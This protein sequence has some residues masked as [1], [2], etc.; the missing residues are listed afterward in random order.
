MSRLIHRSIVAIALGA[1]ASVAYIHDAPAESAA[2]ATLEAGELRSGVLEEIV[3][4]ARKR[5][6]TLQVAP[7]SVTAISGANLEKAQIT[8]IDDLAQ[9]APSLNISRQAGF[10]NSVTVIM[11]GIGDTDP[12]L[13]N[14]SPVAIY[15]DGVYLGRTI[16]S[17]IDLSDLDR[18]E[19]LRGPQGT[20]FGRNTTGGA[21]DIYTK[22]PA[23]VFGLK[24]TLGYASNNEFTSQTFINTG[25][26]G[27][28]GFA[29]K[30]GYRHHQMDGFVNNT[31]AARDA[32]PGADKKDAVY[33]ALRGDLTKD[34]RLDY[35]FD[36]DDESDYSPNYQIVGATPKVVSYFSKS[37]LYGGAPFTPVTPDRLGTVQNEVLPPERLRTL[38]HNVT[39][40]DYVSDAFRIKSITA[41][42]SL[43]ERGS[44]TLGDSGQLKG[45]VFFSATPQNVYLYDT[46]LSNS[47]QH[48]LSEELQF[49][50][51]VDRFN[52]V[53]GLY[54]FDEHVGEQSTTLLTIPVQLGPTFI[55]GFPTTLKLNYTGES[56]SY[57]GYG[58]ASYT[59]PI[60]D[61]KLELTV[62]IRYTKDRKSIEQNDST[63]VRYLRRSFSNTSP[64]FTAK[65]EW[66]RDL[67]TYFRFAQGYKAGGYSARSQGTGYDPEKATSY[68]VGV[69]SEWLDQHLRIN[70]DVYH[71]RYQGLQLNE[72]IGTQTAV[73][74]AG[75]SVFKGGEIEITV[76]PAAGW[77]MNATVGYVNPVYTQFQ[78]TAKPVPPATTGITTDIASTARFP[79][80]SNTT[81]SFST[82]YAFAPT[83]IGDL[84]LRADY[85][86][87]GP[88]YFT[89]NPLPVVG[90][91]Q[92]AVHAPGWSNVGAQVI[93]GNIPTGVGVMQATLYGKNLLQHYQRTGGAD[94][95]Q[96]GFGVV[97]WGRGRV[98][99][100]DV[101]AKF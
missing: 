79:F 39:L 53:A 51:K 80:V 87:Q 2:T 54:Y 67:M 75:E 29:A 14:D 83:P 59:P 84:T 26:I 32:W 8:R 31:L 52:Y 92:Q 95:G 76:L 68:E 89:S 66:N 4:T 23:E 81:A 7:V 34:L 96:L 64:A 25:D 65:Y 5:E 91:F 20:L 36:F 21:I 9:I 93:L 78:Y 15:V 63:A 48:Q 99:G 30:I 19:V 41:Y 90:L 61:D 72:N 71:T 74:N 40:N 86:Y 38:G 43:W 45:L 47:H 44:T 42:R 57:A 70:A 62:G 16:G 88:R 18:V 101:S 73:I 77:Q 17:L 35:R 1:M 37:P 98:V 27:K 11:R 69:K 10:A 22:A 50:G 12:I 49:S 24:Q 82:Q 33:F 56:R 100:I 46:P 60:L 55:K 13:T 6:E 85:A 97:S 58:Q 28:T 94:F 3:V